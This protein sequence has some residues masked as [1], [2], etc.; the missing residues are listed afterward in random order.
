MSFFGIV[1]VIL[2]VIAYYIYI[3]RAINLDIFS[4]NDLSFLHSGIKL[5]FILLNFWLLLLPINMAGRYNEYIGGASAIT[6][7]LDLFYQ[8]ILYANYFFSA[9]FLLWY[10]TRI[11]KKILEK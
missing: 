9:Y 10:I 1:F 8:I 4:N 11:L 3:V 6:S 2:F 7:N 5:L